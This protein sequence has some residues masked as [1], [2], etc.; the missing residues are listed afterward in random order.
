MT[1]PTLTQIM[2][3][4]AT[5]TEKKR[6][7]LDETKILHERITKLTENLVSS[8]EIES[9]YLS[10]QE[11]LKED[12][13][14]LRD[15]NAALASQIAELESSTSSLHNELRT[16]SQNISELQTTLSSQQKSYA[17]AQQDAKEL[18]MELQSIQSSNEERN[19]TLISTHIAAETEKR[20]NANNPRLQ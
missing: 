19:Q 13:L 15:S 12:N 16:K 4:I 9:E 6:S 11:G 18:D 5:L 20:S 8:H 17:I 14:K 2:S 7:F 3:R 1:D 10:K